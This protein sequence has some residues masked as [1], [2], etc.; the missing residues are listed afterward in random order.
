MLSLTPVLAQGRELA[1]RTVAIDTGGREMK[2]KVLAPK[3]AEGPVP[4]IL[5]IHG[6]GYIT[7]GN[8]MVLVSCGKML[9]ERYG[10][11]VVSSNCVRGVC[12]S[13]KSRLSSSR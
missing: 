10:A 13:Q 2:V 12:P 7:G 5:W 11:V 8:Y 4:G 3:R 6:G 9:A 1:L